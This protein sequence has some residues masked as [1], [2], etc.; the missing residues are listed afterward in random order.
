MRN[1][2]TNARLGQGDYL[3]VEA[4]EY[5]RSF[6]TLSPTIAVVTSIEA[7]HL[8]CYRDLDDIRQT[9]A[10]FASAVPLYGAVIGCSDDDNV[11][12]L[13]DGLP[14]RGIRYGLGESA[15]VRAVN[16]RFD[17]SGVSFDVTTAGETLGR[18]DL[19]VPGLHNVRNA[20]AAIAVALELDVPFSVAAAGLA[21][22]TGVERRFQIHGEFN[23]A[24]VVDDYAHHPTEVSA[25]LDAARRGYP[26]RRIVALFQPHLYSRTRDFAAGFAEALGG[27][28]SAFVAPI[29]PAREEPIAGVTSHL[30][31]GG[32]DMVTPLDLDIDGL[33]EHFR[34]L[35]RPG[36]LFIT[37]GAGD[38]H[39]VA[40]ALAAS[41]SRRPTGGGSR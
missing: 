28:H 10:Q 22:Y 40:E 12:A 17:E 20:L 24:I 39:K 21:R 37:M 18:V 41:G 25:T 6:L 9:F 38:V 19:H 13:L 34:G 16:V 8:D 23:G 4:D 36:D 31:S 27:A 7:D 30:I 29:Y 2:S 1:I 14:K 26:S 15:E 32:S 11:I 5:D 3:V 33:T 35:L